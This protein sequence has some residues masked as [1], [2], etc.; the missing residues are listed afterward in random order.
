VAEDPYQYLSSSI[1]SLSSQRAQSSWVARTYKQAAQLY[2]TRRLAEAL[3]AIEPVISPEQNL[4]SPQANSSQLQNGASQAAP[5]ATSSRGTR[6]KVWSFYLTLLNAI[7]ELGAEEGKLA[8]GSAK[9][10]SLAAKA[11]DG[12]IWEDVVVHGYGGAEGG[13]DG[14]VVANLWASRATWSLAKANNDAQG[15]PAA[16]SH[17]VAKSESAA[18]GDISVR[19]GK[20]LIRHRGPYGGLPKWTTTTPQI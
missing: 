15:N 18:N 8:F 1:S 11:K 3:D 19:V 4:T 2:L 20:S 7:I 12:T 14:E 17:A 6:V 5:V 16:Y 9:W 10:R 13:V